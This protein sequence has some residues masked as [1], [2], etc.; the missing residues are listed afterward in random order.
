LS[1]LRPA[2]DEEEEEEEEVVAVVGEADADA[3]AEAE[4]EGAEEAEEEERRDPSFERSSVT[5]AHG[6]TATLVLIPRSC[7]SIWYCSMA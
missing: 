6:S 7:K 2:S 1:P 5:L 4:E 3:E